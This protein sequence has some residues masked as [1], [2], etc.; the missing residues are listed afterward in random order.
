[1]YFPT[2]WGAKEPQN[3]QNHRVGTVNLGVKVSS[4]I[5]YILSLKGNQ[6]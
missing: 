1:M 6:N 3:P 2:N 4:G 5:L